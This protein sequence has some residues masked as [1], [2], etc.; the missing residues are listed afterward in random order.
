MPYAKCPN[1]G[2]VTML[3]TVSLS[4]TCGACGMEFS[5]ELQSDPALPTFSME[6]TP[7]YREGPQ[8]PPSPPVARRRIPVWAILLLVLGPIAF[9]C[10]LAVWG[11]Y[12]YLAVPDH[13]DWYRHHSE[14]G[15]YVALF[16]REPF[17]SH[18]R[19]HLDA[20]STTI[21]TTVRPV[22]YGHFGVSC[23]D[24][25]RKAEFKLEDGLR[26]AADEAGLTLSASHATTH[27]GRRAL[28]GDVEGGPQPRRLMILLA[29]RRVYVVEI[30]GNLEH[31]D[32]FVENFR[33]HK[34]VLDGSFEQRRTAPP[35]PKAR[36]PRE[37]EPEPIRPLEMSKD[38]KT[39]VVYDGELIRFEFNAIGGRAPYSWS[40]GG[41]PREWSYETR[42]R[43]GDSNRL[44]S[45]SCIIEGRS[46][47]GTYMVWA[48]VDDRDGRTEDGKIEI[49]VRELPEDVITL[50]ATPLGMRS[51]PTVSNDTVTIYAGPKTSFTVRVACTLRNRA[52]AAE[53]TLDEKLLPPEGSATPNGDKLEISG[54]WQELGE[55][56]FR[57]SAD[58]CV[59]GFDRTFTVSKEFT[60][61]VVTVP[62]E[63][64]PSQVSIVCEPGE[65]VAGVEVQ[66]SAIYVSASWRS[67]HP[68]AED[69]PATIEWSWK[70]SDVPPGMSVVVDD[71]RCYLT[72]TPTDAGH[73]HLEIWAS[74]TF[75]F[76]T[77]TI[78]A[79]GSLILRVKA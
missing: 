61:L 55:F 68:E 45:T 2:N 58:A 29:V 35:P 39:H 78:R 67:S 52:G 50:T 19:K 51:Y 44:P 24:V 66:G 64:L 40:L 32:F 23:F 63:V 49:E 20:G 3:L 8:T 43:A 38:Q 69:W 15:L 60:L 1:C 17:E 34:E 37:P 76:T 28:V 27:Q 9:I 16:P 14:D 31:W 74:V 5:A 59:S 77:R 41:M 47:P 11:Y 62:E 10:G 65:A 7:V 42:D 79:S 30:E 54:C 73:F 18:E 75:A 26:A 71:R 4:I 56:K 72:G 25:P 48:T 46:P 12:S 53:F 21:Y 22:P 13:D 36:K 70:E 33:I 6:E 57:V